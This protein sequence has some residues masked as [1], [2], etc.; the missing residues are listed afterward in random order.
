MTRQLTLLK[1]NLLPHT[2]MRESHE[3]IQL[4]YNAILKQ[5]GKRY[6]GSH[7]VTRVFVLGNPGAGKSSFVES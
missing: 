3:R 2:Y 6:S 1:V 4:D 7:Y 5:A